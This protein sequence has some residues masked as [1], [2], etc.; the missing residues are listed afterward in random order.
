MLPVTERIRAVV[1]AATWV[2]ACV[3]TAW[4]IWVFAVGGFD[5]TFLGLRIRS[6]NPQRILTIAVVALAGFF[7]AGGTVSPSRTGAAMRRYASR[8]AARPGWIAVAIAA[9]TV[10]I[11]FANSTRIAGG[12]DAYGYVS[13]ADLWRQGTLK[14]PQPWVAEVPWPNAKWT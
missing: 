11:A 4:S 5:T 3:S 10:T 8:I 9:A 7:L 2:V 6:N 1:R 13:Q 14:V 12:A